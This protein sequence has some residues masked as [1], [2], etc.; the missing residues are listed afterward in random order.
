VTVPQAPV[1]Q[2][3]VPQPSNPVTAGPKAVEPV[4]APPIAGTWKANP[5]KKVQIE[6]A[7]RD[8]GRFNWKFTANGRTKDFSGK[9]QLNNQDLTL[10][11]DPDGDA[12]VGTI[13]RTGD[14]GFRFLMKDAE[15]G[16]PGLAFTR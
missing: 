15:T 3:P 8:D 9:Y 14:N 7:L 16:D 13:E 4:S 12:M 2:A 10:T 1:A 6:L 5:E 11:R